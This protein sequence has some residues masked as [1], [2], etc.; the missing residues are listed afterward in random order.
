MGLP[1]VIVASI[2]YQ[3]LQI[4][5][6]QTYSFQGYHGSYTVTEDAYHYETDFTWNIGVGFRWNI[7][8][9]LFIKAMG[10][11]QWLQY[12]GANNIT[13]QIEGFFVIGWMFRARRVA[14]EP[15]ITTRSGNF[16]RATALTWITAQASSG[17]ASFASQSRHSSQVAE[18]ELVGGICPLRHF[19]TSARPEMPRP[20]R[21]RMPYLD[22]PATRG[23]WVTGISL[24]IAPPP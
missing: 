15:G 19:R 24:T 22:R 1:V 6:S 4:D 13:T 14:L 21:F 9:Q 5:Q 10:G 2:G 11:A 17:S 20:R 7:S 18:S 23:W 3:Y 12:S 16:C 8:D